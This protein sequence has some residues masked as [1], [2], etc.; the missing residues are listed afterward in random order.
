MMGINPSSIG[1]T[2][3]LAILARTHI[4]LPVYADMGGALFGHPQGA[5]SI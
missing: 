1:L 4:A 2:S 3:D 5:Q